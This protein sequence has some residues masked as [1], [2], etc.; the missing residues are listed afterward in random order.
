MN[1][2]Q[3]NKLIE[4]LTSDA[5]SMFWDFDPNAHFNNI[6]ITI[7]GKA[8]TYQNTSIKTALDGFFNQLKEHSNEVIYAEP[9]SDERS[10][11]TEE[12]LTTQERLDIIEEQLQHIISF[13]SN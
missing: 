7:N 6:T 10:T 4:S 11:P 8:T 9:A 13:L 3:V 12:D 5:P 1:Q 2:Q